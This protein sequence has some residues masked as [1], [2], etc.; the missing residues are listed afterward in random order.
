MTFEQMQEK[1]KGSKVMNPP[2]ATELKETERVGGESK[3]NFSPG[4]VLTYAGAAPL[5]V[6]NVSFRISGV[7]DEVM[8]ATING[9]EYRFKWAAPSD[10]LSWRLQQFIHGYYVDHKDATE[11]VT[12]AGFPG[13]ADSNGWQTF[14]IYSV[15]TD[16]ASYAQTKH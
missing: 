16:L 9:V 7:G 13:V 14:E 6:G 8:A 1:L 10:N 12:V 11:A 2:P 15:T 3:G 4:P 5:S